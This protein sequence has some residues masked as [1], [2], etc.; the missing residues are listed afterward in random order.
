[1]KEA[2]LATTFITKAWYLIALVS[3]GVAL[4][5]YFKGTRKNLLSLI[6]KDKDNTPERDLA[7]ALGEID[8]D[9]DRIKEDGFTILNEALFATKRLF[10]GPVG[11][12]VGTSHLAS[13]NVVQSLLNN[14]HSSNPRIQAQASEWLLKLSSPQVLPY[15]YNKVSKS[16][17]SMLT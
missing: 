15:D 6:S 10:S 5:S 3:A 12:P 8:N 1:M 16:V 13:Q 9:V 7:T 2:L 14:I 11:L 4:F 17:A